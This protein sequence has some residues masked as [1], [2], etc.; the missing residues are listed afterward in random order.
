M[1]GESRHEV[2]QMLQAWRHGDRT[3]LDGLMPVLY[4]EMHRLAHICMR[5][6]WASHTFQTS[7]L[8]NEAYLRLI[9][10]NQVDWQD[11]THFFA[12]CAHIMRQTLMQRARLRCAQKRGGKA[13][14]VELDEAF[15]PSPERDGDLIALDDALDLLAQTDPREAKVVELRFFA[16]LSEE[17]VAHAL[18]ISVRTV[19]REWEHAKVWLMRQL[20]RGAQA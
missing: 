3:A 12:I 7:A 2:T 11:R 19:R 9:D 18:G 1:T 20:K 8:I 5:R 15:I 10:A 4:A 14:R 13:V 16:G 6:E 17:E